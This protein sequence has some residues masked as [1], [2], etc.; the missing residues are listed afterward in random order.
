MLQLCAGL[1]AV[2]KDGAARDALQ[3]KTTHHTSAME[4]QL[5]AQPRLNQGHGYG[6]MPPVGLA[7]PRGSTLHHHVDGVGRWVVLFSFGLTCDFHVAGRTVSIE[8]GDAL[9]FNGGGAH[10]VMH[11]LDRVHARPS[12]DGEHKE[13]PSAMMDA[14]GA[15]RVS[16]QVRQM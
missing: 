11:G 16:V 8:S 6:W 4:Q 10:A 9:V 15:T 7:Y 14:L 1:D 13:L 5:G 2:K 12:L 3:N